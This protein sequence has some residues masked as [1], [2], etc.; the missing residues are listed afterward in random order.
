M[1]G[2]LTLL[3]PTY[4]HRLIYTFPCGRLQ[5]GGRD[6]PRPYEEKPELHT[7]AKATAA[8]ASINIGKS[9]VIRQP[10]VVLL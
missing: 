3:S 8:K 4:G 1:F 10:T 9:K 2:F 7:P 6:N 5:R